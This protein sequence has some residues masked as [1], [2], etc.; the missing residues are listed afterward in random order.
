[1]TAYSFKKQFVAPVRVGLG[2]RVDHEPGDA[3]VY[4]PKR[5]T[6]RADRKRHARVG[7]E[8]QLYCG[9]RTKHCFLIGRSR[10]TAVSRIIIW[11]STMAIMIAGK[12]LTA[13]QIGAFVK[14]DGFASVHDMNQFWNENHP[15]VDKFEGVLIEWE[16]L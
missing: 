7:E 11:T 15:G 5:Q 2:I 4:H 6:I 9:M 14:A 1:M 3:H 13:R 16:P 8:L 12:L 10:C